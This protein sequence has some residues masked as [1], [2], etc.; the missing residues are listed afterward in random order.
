MA[1]DPNAKRR[2]PD[3]RVRNPPHI[4]P[5]F[6]ELA[7]R[8]TRD[9]DGHCPWAPNPQPRGPWRYVSIGEDGRKLHLDPTCKGLNSARA[10]GY[11]TL[12]AEEALYAYGERYCS[13]CGPGTAGVD[14]DDALYAR[15]RLLW[16][17]LERELDAEYPDCPECHNM[18]TWTQEPGGGLYCHECG[19]VPDKEMHEEIQGE[20][21]RLLGDA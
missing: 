14:A 15:L 4:A 13:H 20:W 10:Q 19:H 16:S 6:G 2:G 3:Q 9:L 17:Y 1:T 8:C 7:F 11:K 5:R 12:G 21:N 18:E